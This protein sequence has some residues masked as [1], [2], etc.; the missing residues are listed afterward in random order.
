MPPAVSLSH[1]CC[2][3][4]HCTPRR[5]P[6]PPLTSPPAQ[7]APPAA[8][9]APRSCVVWRPVG[10]TAS[11]AQRRPAG[12]KE[13]F[14]GEWRGNGKGAWRCIGTCIVASPASCLPHPAHCCSRRTPAATP[15]AGGC[16]PAATCPTLLAQHPAHLCRRAHEGRFVQQLLHL[17]PHQHQLGQQAPA[18]EAG[19]SRGGWRRVDGWRRPAGPAVAPHVAR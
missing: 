18:G 8:A 6:G 10:G 11:A 17:L 13:Q 14:A 15:N 19:Q 5:P 1:S 7:A 9:A 16:K 3:H 4:S 12:R 2:H